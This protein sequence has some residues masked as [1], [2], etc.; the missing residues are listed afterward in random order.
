MNDHQCG[1][2]Q[3]WKT[4]T[5]FSTMKAIIITSKSTVHI[6][7][8]KLKEKKN[9]GTHLYEITSFGIHS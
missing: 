6:I 8:C 9:Y 5:P 4:T 3:N 1:Y 2:S 7:L